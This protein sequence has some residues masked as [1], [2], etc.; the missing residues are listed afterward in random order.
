[1]L[2]KLGKV[3]CRKAAAQIDK[4]DN[5]LVLLASGWQKKG[6][7]QLTN[8]RIRSSRGQSVPNPVNRPH[9]RTGKP[10]SSPAKPCRYAKCQQLGH[11][12]S[13]RSPQVHRTSHVRA[14]LDAMDP[15]RKT[16]VRSPEALAQ[17]PK[18]LK[19][20]P[21]RLRSPKKPGSLTKSPHSTTKTTERSPSRLRSPKPPV[22]ATN[23]VTKRFAQ[24]GPLLQ[25]SKPS[26]VRACISLATTLA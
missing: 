22:S 11:L 26:A 7:L 3:Q 19:R 25:P 5:G 2:E 8:R 14:R 4:T 15:T 10:S 17:Q 18:P 9:T 16:L 24:Q 12:K 21:S 6:Y 23:T 1:M 20:S 13:A